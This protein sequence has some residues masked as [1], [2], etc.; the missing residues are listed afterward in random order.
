VDLNM[1][2]R[3]LPRQPFG[4][5]RPSLLSDDLVRALIAAGQVDVLVGVP[6]LDNAKTIRKV[7]QAV[8]TAFA[9]PLA[10]QRTVL[11]DADGGSTDGSADIVRGARDREDELI[12]AAHPLRTVHRLS[13]PYHGNV[14]RANALRLVFA[15]ADLASARAV[16]IVDPESTTLTPEGIA[17]LARPVLDGKFDLVKPL[18]GSSPWERPLITQLVSPLLRAAYGRRL[19]DPITTQFACSGRFA[20]GTVASEV[21]DTPLAEN[22]LDS[23]LTVRALADPARVAQVWA[24]GVQ[25]PQHA[26]RPAAAEVFQ[27]VVGA[28]FESLVADLGRWLEIRGCSDTTTLGEPRPPVTLRPPFDVAAFTDVFTQGVRELPPLLRPILGEELLAQLAA[29]AEQQPVRVPPALWASAVFHAL[30]GVHRRALPASQVV[31]ALYP[32]YLGRVGSFTGESANDSADAA[33]ARLEDVG[34]A[35]ESAKAELASLF[36]PTT[37]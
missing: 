34:L 1:E 7:I 30:A 36:A 3:A 26:R 19:I 10:R 13:T 14:G 17:S 32:L 20:A 31:G 21:W 35:F 24:P 11:L 28:L 37:R 9:G 6:T 18:S 4:R 8:L 25:E 2:S 12:V 33:A 15:A 29:A 16:V 27:Q 5:N 22:G 23:W